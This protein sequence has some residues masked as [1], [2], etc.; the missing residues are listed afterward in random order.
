[1]FGR[2]LALLAYGALLPLGA[3]ACQI[4]GEQSHAATPP[5]EKTQEGVVVQGDG[6]ARCVLPP[7]DFDNS[8]L[9]GTWVAGFGDETDTLIFR[10][11]GTYRQIVNFG[12]TGYRFEGDWRKWWMETGERGTS[13]LHLQGMRLCVSYVLPNCEFEG[14][15]ETRWWDFCEDRMVSM[16]DEGILIVLGVQEGLFQPPRGIQLVPLIRDADS[17][18]Y[19]Y[20]LEP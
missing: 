14:G 6:S 20:W 11:D 3:I 4:T 12:A 13:Y 15:G 18:G 10:E 5:A 7:G 19:S 2:R 1:M 8:N 16:P 17:H 9:T